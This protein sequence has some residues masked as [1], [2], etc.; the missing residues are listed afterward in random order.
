MQQH[1]QSLAAKPFLLSLARTHFHSSTPTSFY[2]RTMATAGT[3][4]E[5]TEQIIIDHNNVRDLFERCVSL[6]FSASLR[7][8]QQ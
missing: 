4:L 6:P 7:A 8:Q 2:I 5:V 3:R 1:M